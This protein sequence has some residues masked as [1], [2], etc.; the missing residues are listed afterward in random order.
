MRK[1]IIAILF[2]LLLGTLLIPTLFYSSAKIGN[3]YESQPMSSGTGN[4]L[5]DIQ[6]EIAN[7]LQNETRPA[8]WGSKQVNMLI[9]C[10][11]QP[12]FITA[13][14]AYALWKD[15]RGI[16]SEVASNYSL[17]E[18]VDTPEKIRNLIKSYY[19]SYNLEFVLLLGDTDLIPVRYVKNFDT[20][21]IEDEHESFGLPGGESL[22]PT[23]FYYAELTGNWNIDSDDYWGE[24]PSNNS[25]SDEYEMDFIPE[26][27]VGR[28]PAENPTELYYLLNKSME[29]ESGI[30]LNSNINKFLALS[31]ISDFA[32][33]EDLDGEDEG[34]LV[35]YVL[36][37]YIEGNMNW[38]HGNEHTSYYTPANDERVVSLGSINVAQEVNNGLSMLFFA[39]HGSKTSLVSLESGYPITTSKLANWNNSILPFVY[40]SACSTNCYD[41]EGSL[42]EKIL[43]HANGGAI[44]YVGSMRVSWYYPNDTSLEQVNRG[45]SKLFF[46]QMFANQQFQQGR[47]LYEA[48]TSYVNSN[49]FQMAY[50]SQISPNSNFNFFE[51]ERKTLLSYMLLGDPSID[52]YTQTLTDAKLAIPQDTPVY[53]NSYLRIP[54]ETSN[55]DAI[56]YARIKLETEEGQQR[57]FQ[58]NDE[59]V[60][61]VLTPNVDSVNYTIYGHNVNS[62]QPRT[63]TLEDDTSFPQ[64]ES[65]LT[66]LPSTLTI[67]DTWQWEFHFSD[68]ESGPYMVYFIRLDRWKSHYDI[69]EMNANNSLYWNHTT[70]FTFEIQDFEP[71]K[72]YYYLCGIDGANLMTE[73]FSD[74]LPSLRIVP[75][76]EIQ[77]LWVIPGIFLVGISVIFMRQIIPMF[78][79]YQRNNIK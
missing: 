62:S 52:I 47:A 34:Y 28:L 70:K 18:G 42:G 48:K 9:I 46:K 44:G 59:G 49:W 57:I 39:G 20:I 21:I 50:A 26:V 75:L 43:L 53:K 30:N 8:N 31:A 5:S 76:E 11:D 38:I 60:V 13:A 37:H 22:K 1:H 4:S 29:Y 19:T 24:N 10:P 58:A 67:N 32:T 79:Q 12:E 71:G 36:D 74:S 54:V 6:A 45:M 68:S 41:T 27:Y 63:L 66:Y 77:L 56:P 7:I 16:P 72:Y 3:D 14:N 15:S 51:M 61:S 73:A 35:Q 25:V 78:S 23:D 64:F 65:D 40:A 55:G 2:P 33:L 69:F 17:Y